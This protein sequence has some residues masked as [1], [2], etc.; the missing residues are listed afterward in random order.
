MDES[1]HGEGLSG[2]KKL[3]RG[4]E[5]RADSDLLEQSKRE[6]GIASR[7]VHLRHL[8][9][10]SVVERSSGFAGFIIAFELILADP[11]NSD[12][13]FPFF[14]R[15]FL[16]QRLWLPICKKSDFFS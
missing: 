4:S 6:R 12:R 7:D 16:R 2:R 14:V 9:C 5:Y 11:S 15:L 13:L 3:Y 8:A 1:S 10:G